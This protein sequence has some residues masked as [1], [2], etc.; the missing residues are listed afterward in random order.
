MLGISENLRV[1]FEDEE[2]S[3]EELD[4]TEELIDRLEQCVHLCEK[5]ERY[6]LMLEVR[7][8]PF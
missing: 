5:S 8:V 4:Y 2:D 6:E 3:K 1:E 7:S